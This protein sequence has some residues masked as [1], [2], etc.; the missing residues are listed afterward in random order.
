MS[1]IVVIEILKMSSLHYSEFPIERTSRLFG[2]LPAE[3]HAMAKAH[4]RK[5]Y[6]SIG[7]C[8]VFQ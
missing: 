7:T 6:Q 8:T 4:Y 2:R 1:L 5:S 3:W